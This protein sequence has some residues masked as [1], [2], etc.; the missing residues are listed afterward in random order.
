MEW[1][2]PMIVMSG[3]PKARRAALV[4]QLL[5]MALPGPR[6]QTLA[7]AAMSA[8]QQ[9]KRQAQAEQQL[10]EAAIEAGGIKTTEELEKFPVLYAAFTRL[11]AAT[12]T[13]IFASTGDDTGGESRRR[14]RS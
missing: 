5:P 11:P 2:L 8:E 4:E 10:L 3:V 14:G 7:L 9:M 1:L 12:Q 6:A 13:A